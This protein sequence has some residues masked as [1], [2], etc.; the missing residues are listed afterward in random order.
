MA[1]GM[2][3]GRGRVAE[4]YAWGDSQALKLFYSNRSPAWAENEAHISRIAYAAGFNT[5]A[6]GTTIEVEGR[7][8]IL[9]ERVDGIAMLTEMSSKPWTLFRNARILAEQHALMHEKVVTD[10]PSQQQ[11]LEQSILSATAL[12]LEQKEVAINAVQQLPSGN[13][14][15][16]GDFHPD[17]IIL[18]ADGP[19]TIDWTTASQGNP[20][21]DVART[22]L[23]LQLGDPPP[24]TS[25]LTRLLVT[26][27]R[28]LFHKTYLKRY[29][30]LQPDYQDQLAA[31]QYPM[32]AARLGDGIVEEQAQLLALLAR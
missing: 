25:L 21:A 19:V 1:K 4:V 29:F 2:L 9:F 12:S 8:G 7:Q 31:W 22:S 18:S 14:L 27:G 17:N 30:E 26:A 32:M 24:G 5:P 16:H 13:R 6:V 23:I 10:L 15:C 28:G 20:L 11:H 3:I